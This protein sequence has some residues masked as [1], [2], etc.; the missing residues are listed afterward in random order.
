MGFG[1]EKLNNEFWNFRGSLPA[2]VGGRTSRAGLPSTSRLYRV[3]R[4]LYTPAKYRKNLTATILR[5]F[6]AAA[7]RTGGRVGD[8]VWSGIFRLN[9]CPGAKKYV[10]WGGGGKGPFART[11]RG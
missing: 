8:P 11:I 9:G 6:M 4:M 10:G 1:N 3:A 5:T 7:N 2:V